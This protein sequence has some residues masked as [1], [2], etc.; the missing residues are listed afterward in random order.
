VQKPPHVVKL[1]ITWCSEWWTHLRDYF[2][3]ASIHFC[4]NKPQSYL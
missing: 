1:A 4:G 3:R 2:R